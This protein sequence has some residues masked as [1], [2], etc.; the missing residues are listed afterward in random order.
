[1]TTC[2]FFFFLIFWRICFVFVNMGPYGSQNFKTPLLPQITFEYFRTF[3]DF[4]YQWSSQKYCFEFLK[5][6]VFDFS[7]FFFSF[8][9]T[10]DSMGAKTSKRYSS[11][12][13][14]LNLFN[15]FL[16]FLLNGP[17]KSTVL[18]FWNFEFAIFN[19]F[20]I[21]PYGRN[22]KPQLSGKRVI[23]ERNGVKFGPRS[24]VFSVH[25]V[26]LTFSN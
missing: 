24:W 15:L 18:D 13:S 7:G 21:V 10:W 17:Q 2:Y 19:D 11:H 14:L 23:V 5:F 26:R 12:K 20:T 8:S 4:F 22:Q 1:M 6:R 3:S 25:M 16:N 9:L